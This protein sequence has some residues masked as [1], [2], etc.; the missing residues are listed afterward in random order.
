MEL[1]TDLLTRLNNMPSKSYYPDY[2]RLDASL[3]ALD[4]YSKSIA[5]D[6]LDWNKLNGSELPASELFEI[7][8]KERNL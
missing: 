4:E 7:Y 3:L 5:I 6:F 2:I 8:K 1:K